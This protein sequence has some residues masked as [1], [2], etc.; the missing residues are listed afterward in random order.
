MFMMKICC[1]K[2]RDN[3]RV[4]VPVLWGFLTMT[5][6]NVTIAA[7]KKLDCEAEFVQVMEDVSRYPDL[8]SKIKRME[9]M[10]QCK[11]TGIYESRLGEFYTQAGRY[12]EARDVIR[13][14]LSRKSG[15][16]KNLRL[17]LSGVDF[18][19]GNL[20]LAED[21]A[22][23]LIKN[24]P[25]WAGGYGALAEVQLVQQHFQDGI[26]NLERANVLEPSSGAYTLLTMAYYKM[27]RPRDAAVAM[28]KALRLDRD[29]LKHTQ[30]VCATAYSLVALGHLPEAEELLVKHLTVQPGA[31]ND[32]TY[33]AATALVKK[34]I[35]E[36]NAV[37]SP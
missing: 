3:L 23:A 25:E 28:Q 9:A 8:Q 16:E 10:A 32:P 15:Y 27:N 1:W 22:R 20:S 18:H 5:D 7:A 37:P 31:A 12:T 13:S 36:Q 33:Q 6:P 30:A 29:A 4:I 11:G 26:E 2:K 21:E 35:Q 14:G 17:G 24:Y 34:K 19:Q